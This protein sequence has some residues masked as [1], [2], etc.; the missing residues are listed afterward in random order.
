MIVALARAKVN[1]GF[2]ASI[3][4]ALGLR[5]LANLLTYFRNISTHTWDSTLEGLR[6]A[7][8]TLGSRS[9]SE[10]IKGE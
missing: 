4:A 6:T 1:T 2:R 9:L 3:S 5:L 10:K 7:M 8:T